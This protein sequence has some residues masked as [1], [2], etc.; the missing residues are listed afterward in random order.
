[1][2]VTD[3]RLLVLLEGSQF[4]HIVF[5]KSTEHCFVREDTS[6]ER[7]IPSTISAISSTNT[8]LNDASE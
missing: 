2:V 6:L 5:G 4:E 3:M 1:M 8:Y 7:P